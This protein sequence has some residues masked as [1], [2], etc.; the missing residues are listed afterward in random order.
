MMGTWL[1]AGLNLPA[2][3]LAGYGANCTLPQH[4]LFFLPPWWEYI[5]TKIDTVTK[6]CVVAFN[7]PGDIWSVALA[8][9]DML[10]RIGGFVAV[11]S[12]IIA[13]LQYITSM[14]NS[15][16]NVNARKRLTNSL[17][18]LAIVLIA[19]GVVAFIGNQFGGS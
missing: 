19:S 15:E 6:Q 16:D 18:G 9:L 2:F 12:I 11:I 5:P 14:G 7:F 13:G 8:V 4:S 3:W 1:I 17:I 10:L